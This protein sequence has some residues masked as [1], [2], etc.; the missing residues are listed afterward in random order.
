[1]SSQIFQSASE[2]STYFRCDNCCMIL[3]KVSWKQCRVCHG[4]DLCEKCAN[5]GYDKLTREAFNQH[6]RLHPDLPSDAS[7]VN[8]LM[9][10]VLIEEA[11]KNDV[12]ARRKRGEQILTRVLKDEEIQDDYDMAALME[13]LKKQDELSLFSKD[14]KVS[15]LNSIILKY[16][17]KASQRRI[18]VLSL[19]GGGVRGYMPI[20]IIG[21]LIQ[22]KYNTIPK[23]FDANNSNHKQLFHEAQLEFTKNFDYFVGTSTGGLIAFCLAINYNILDMQEIYSNASHYFKKNFFGPVITSKYD[24]IRIHT[25]IEEIID[26]IHFPV[27]KKLTHENATLLDIRNLLNPDNIIDD[28]CIEAARMKYGD[29]L[30]FTDIINSKNE[31]AHTTQGGI[32]QQAKCEKVLLITSYNTT[33]NTVTMFNTSYAQHWGY[34][35]A[36]VL[37]STMAAPTYFPPHPIYTTINGKEESSPQSTPELFIDGGVFANDPELAALWA[38]RIQWKKP[39]N[40]HLLSIGTGCYTS[41]LSSSTWGG[42]IGWVLNGG[43]LVNTLMDATRSFTERIGSNLANL[44]NL[45]RMKLNYKITQP[46]ALDDTKFAEKFDKEWEYL[47]NEQDFKALI[48][49][50]D[51]YIKKDHADDK[52]DKKSN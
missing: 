32:F 3:N 41:T 26:S 39:I 30:E 40:Y 11:V 8:D 12:E 13:H 21:E 38:V 1:M 34:R 50:Y 17:L 52:N 19:D 10:L 47:K 23:P 25:K 51:N 20:K 9:Q 48:Y 14:D 24:P 4:F 6:Q 44:S 45:R 43:I 5:I 29:L 16:N 35:I 28:A 2:I 36:D 27:E 46:M 31:G 49:F 33:Q 7:I 42:Y 37:K 15:Q 18:R 22:Q